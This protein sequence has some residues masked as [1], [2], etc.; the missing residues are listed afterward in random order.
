MEDEDAFSVASKVLLETSTISG[1]ME[2]LLMENGFPSNRAR[3]VERVLE[4]FTEA[5]YQPC[6]LLRLCILGIREHM[7][8]KLD[9]DF[10]RL[11]LPPR[12]RSLVTF[13]YV[14]TGLG[15]AL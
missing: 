13:E 3:D 14:L 1:T 7:T 10:D 4:Q 9:K 8:S 15:A 2:E 12:L 5:G 6:S 11:S